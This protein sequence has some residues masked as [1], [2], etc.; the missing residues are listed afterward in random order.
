MK[1]TKNEQIASL[2]REVHQNIIDGNNVLTTAHVPPVLQGHNEANGI[3]GLIAEILK[4]NGAEF[5]LGVETT[6]FRK[7]AV[8]AGMFATDIAAQV[9]LRF[10]AGSSRYPKESVQVYLAVY[11][12]KK[13][14]VGKIQLT[15]YEDKDRPCSCCKPRTKYFLVQG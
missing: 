14:L 7:I 3:T 15:K 1:T 12:A 9:Q 4:D 6:E 13:G 2:V 10:S 5:P 8:A 11:L